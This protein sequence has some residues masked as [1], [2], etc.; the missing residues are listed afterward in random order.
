MCL[1]LPLLLL[2]L[3]VPPSS[4]SPSFFPSSSS[5]SS[6][7]FVPPPSAELN[8]PPI[9]QSDDRFNNN[10]NI[11]RLNG[12]DVEK[13]TDAQLSDYENC[14][15]EF[16]NE[17]E[18]SQT[19]HPTHPF[20]TPPLEYPLKIVVE[21]LVVEQVDTLSKGSTEFNVFGHMLISWNDSRFGWD[22]K[23]W[24]LDELELKDTQTQEVWTPSFTDETNCGAMDGCL[25]KVGDLTLTPSGRVTSR[26]VFRYPSFCR[27]DYRSYPEER[28]DCCL[29]ISAADIGRTVK[30]VVQMD[31]RRA[32]LSSKSVPVS[33]VAQGLSAIVVTNMETSVW[34]VQRQSLESIRIEG[35]RGEHLQLCV[36]AKKEMS[37]LRIALR[38]PVTI[39]TLLMLVSPLFG[40]LRTQALVKLLTLLLQTICFL[41]LC[42]IA[43]AN[44]FGGSKPKLYTFYEFMFSMT[45]LSILITTV[46]LALCRMK[47]TVPASHGLFLA[48]KMLNHFLCCVE[49]DPSTNYQR[50][51]DDGFD[52]V[53]ARGGIPQAPNSGPALQN[54][55][56]TEWRHIYIAANNL[57][58]GICFSLFCFVTIFEI[59]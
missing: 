34:A 16:L 6:S 42:S 38:I 32:L 50:Q 2:S 13:L 18:R 1:L 44:G 11:W 58:S 8:I 20:I 24:H 56:S 27:I 52:S 59:M 54:D 48:A 25:S 28:N 35:N 9:G 17:R 46:C 19:V 41:F 55:Y 15:W 45:F 40:D 36:Q 10:C 14:L 31:Q 30:F 51:F 39:A 3:L 7:F 37:T 49:P 26:L 12:T 5:S 23:E 53:S 43:P 22:T 33:R 57:F 47:R 29:Y 21:H 4:S